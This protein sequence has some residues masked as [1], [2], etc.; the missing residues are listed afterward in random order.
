MAKP[1]RVPCTPD[2]GRRYRTIGVIAAVVFVL[3]QL[4][5]LWIQQAIPVWEK[6]FT[7]IPGF[8]DIVHILNRGAAFGFLNRDDID[9]QRPFFI[10]VSIVAVG[11]IGVLAKS[12]EDDGPFYV[13]GLGL[14]LGGALGN[15]LDRVRLGV[16]V[17]FLDFYVADMHWPAF[18]VADMGI[19]IGA[20][21]L[22]VSFYQQ[23]RRCVPDNT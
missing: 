7:V 23:R 11:L 10:A 21:A 17:D 18:N 8:F 1:I 3:D 16:V 22:L 19:C 13:Y 2:M 12:K 5:K 15:L 6:G 4:T 9:W 14:I 20:G